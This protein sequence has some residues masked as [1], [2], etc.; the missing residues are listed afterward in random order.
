MKGVMLLRESP[1]KLPTQKNTPKKKLKKSDP[2]RVSRWVRSDFPFKET[3]SYLQ[4]NP[5]GKA[6]ASLE[7]AVEVA[8]RKPQV[9]MFGPP[10]NQ[11]KSRD[12]PGRSRQYTRPTKQP[13][14]PRSGLGRTTTE[15]DLELGEIASCL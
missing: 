9:E 3:A 7:V 13:M 4:K 6:T 11:G 15:R 1:P 2:S 10:K 8:G 12:K 14:P 5:S